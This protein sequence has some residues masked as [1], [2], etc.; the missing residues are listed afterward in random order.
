MKHPFHNCVLDLV[1]LVSVALLLYCLLS[2]STGVRTD[3]DKVPHSKTA[4]QY[5]Q[6]YR[7]ETRIHVI[8]N[9]I[10]LSFHW[11]WKLLATWYLPSSDSVFN[12]SSEMSAKW[13]ALIINL[14][15]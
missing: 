6:V 9:H 1:D 15:S 7:Y 12:E 2:V 3:R 11:T 13:G 14:S 4:K 8:M 5:S 10:A